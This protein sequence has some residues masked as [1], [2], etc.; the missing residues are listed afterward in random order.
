MARGR[1]D[2]TLQGVVARSVPVKDTRDTSRCPVCGTL[3]VLWL[4]QLDGDALR[5]HEHLHPPLAQLA[6]DAALLVAAEGHEGHAGGVVG[7]DPDGA[8]LDP[9]GELERLIDVLGPDGS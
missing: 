9:F 1:V 2:A 8:R 7:V 4:A 6:A 3:R 5:L